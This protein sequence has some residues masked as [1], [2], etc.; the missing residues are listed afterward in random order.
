MLFFFYLLKRFSFLFA[1][2]QKLERLQEEELV[3]KP[4]E[5]K[6]MKIRFPERGQSGRSVVTIKNLEFGFEDKVRY[7]DLI[8]ENL[9]IKMWTVFMS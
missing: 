7:Q 6:Q 4:F 3:E 9:S 2:Q 1:W 8:I 5:R